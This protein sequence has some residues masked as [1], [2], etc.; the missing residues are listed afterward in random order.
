MSGWEK[1]IARSAL[2]QWIR[3]HLPSCSL[4]FESHAH[5]HRA[6]P[7]IVIC[8][9]FVI[10]MR[11]GQKKQKKKPGLVHI[12]FFKKRF[13]ESRFA[14]QI[15]S[16]NVNND[17]RTNYGPLLLTSPRHPRPNDSFSRRWFR[18][19]SV[20]GCIMVAGGILHIDC[21]VVVTFQNV[22]AIGNS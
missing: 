22:S 1:E 18:G 6:C 12:L 14:V 8:P 20:M 2:A 15:A 21:T 11:K 5:H 4:R 16:A 17:V 19:I 13:L 9:L 7:F 3:L 10:A